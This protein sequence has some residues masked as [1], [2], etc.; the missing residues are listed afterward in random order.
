MKKIIVTCDTK[1]TLPFDALEVFQGNLKKRNDEDYRKITESILKHGFA[2]PFF[3]W[4][5]KGHNW[6][7]DGTGRYEALE[8]MQ[9]MGF[10]FPDFPVVY[11]KA[12]SDADARELLLKI[13]SQYGKVSSKGLEEFI[14]GLEID[15]DSLGLNV[16]IRRDMPEK[17][18]AVPAAPKKPLTRAGDIYELRGE[19]NEV[20][21]RLACGDARDAALFA[22]LMGDERAALLFTDPPY[23]VNIGEKIED[24]KRGAHKAN[25]AR[26]EENIPNSLQGDN[27]TPEQLKIL[28]T[29]TLANAGKFMRDDAAF[30]LC[31]GSFPRL[32]QMQ[33]S[34]MKESG[35][36]ARHLLIWCKNQAIFSMNRTDYDYQH[37]L[38]WYGWKNKHRFYGQGKYKTSLWNFTRPQKS[39]LHPTMKPPALIEEAIKNSME[40]VDKKVCGIA[41]NTGKNDIVL[42][43]FA[44]SGS[45][46]AACERL[47]RRAFMIEIEPQY[48]DL[49]IRR[50]L[51][52]NPSFA[53]FRIRGGGGM[54]TDVT[55]KFYKKQIEGGG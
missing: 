12:G 29:K 45:A 37:E 20:R 14:K 50:A 55:G 2:T 34:A 24:M 23:G 52:L 30:Y 27:I 13:T 3:V 21:H 19:G 54:G 17:F 25:A 31:G 35:L 39:D 36:E 38:I 7:L 9:I 47:K 1:D 11:V 6:L 16:F 44:G 33:L 26:Q 4:K 49:I 10:D 51:E 22:Q 48:C 32:I 5:N 18:S 28:L 46:M 15:F 41:N 40:P 8:R 43:P 42:D 53:V